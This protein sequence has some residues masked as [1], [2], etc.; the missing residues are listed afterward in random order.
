MKKSVLENF[1]LTFG[2]KNFGINESGKRCNYPIQ[3]RRRNSKPMEGEGAGVRIY[4]CIDWGL[5]LQP[6]KD[7]TEKLIKWIDNNFIPK[8]KI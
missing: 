8:K 2:I 4:N 6:E 1:N 3:K 5:D 7:I